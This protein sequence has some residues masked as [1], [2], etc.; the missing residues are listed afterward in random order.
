MISRDE[1]GARAPRSRDYVS[2]GDRT[3]FIVHHSAGPTT[4]TVRSIQDYHMDGNGWSDIGYNSLVDDEGNAYEGRGWL[5]AG[6]HAKGHNTS[7]IGV[8]YIG[9]NAPTPLAKAAIRALYDQACTESGRTLAKKTHG[10]VNNTA[11]PASS[12]QSWV[13]DGM[14]G[15]SAI[16][17]E[18]MK[19]I[20]N[21]RHGDGPET[22]KREHVKFLQLIVRKAGGEL[23]QYGV[24]GWYGDELAAAVLDV[25][26]QAGSNQDFGDWVSGWCAF[27]AVDEYIRSV[28]RDETAAA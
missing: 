8:C 23:P 16:L 13:D 19:M 20:I 11:C 22:G 26:K 18:G 5:V 14:P 3:E 28:V 10:D 25:R 6:A 7:G 2:W 17:E 12:L 24:D 4:Q 27:Q 21:L 9:Q 1:W 15:G